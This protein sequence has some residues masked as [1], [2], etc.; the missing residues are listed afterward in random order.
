MSWIT[1]TTDGAMPGPERGL[2]LG[3][4]TGPE[5][6]AVLAQALRD[7]RANA[8]AWSQAAYSRPRA[9][10]QAARS[11]I[12]RPAAAWALGCV[13]AAGGLSGALY[14]HHQRETMARLAL[15]EREVQQ[16]QQAA[17]Q[18]RT[19]DEDLLATVDSDISRDVPAAMEPLA[20]L[21][22]ENAAQ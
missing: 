2:E 17:Q 3:P 11:S 19:S 1:K 9:Q 16:R 6:D 12:W 10:A 15:H 21:M 5:F 22:D 4:E 20:Q 7:F 14:E 8:H 18:Q 13:L